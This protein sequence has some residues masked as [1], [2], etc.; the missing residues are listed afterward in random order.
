MSARRVALAIASSAV[1][2]AFP[3]TGTTAAREG[4]VAFEANWSIHLVK[5]DGSGLRVLAAEGER[6]PGE[7][8][9]YLYYPS[10]A[11]DGSRVTYVN[12]ARVTH[13]DVL[14]RRA[15]GGGP[16]LFGVDGYLL[17]SPL[18]FSPD[19]GSAAVSRLGERTGELAVFI[20]D[21]RGGKERQLT[22][23]PAPQR[24]TKDTRPDW[25]PDG[26]SIA[27]S[28]LQGTS[29][30]LM[31]VRVLGGPAHRLTRGAE[32]DWAPN[33]RRIAFVRRD[34]VYVCRRDGTAVRRIVKADGAASP[35][36]APDG[37]RVAYTADGSVWVV[38]SSGGVPVKIAN[39]VT[40][41][42]DWG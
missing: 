10:F 41:D 20:S 40:G 27:F 22:G 16:K 35:D 30:W 37:S 28:R 33:G 19:G 5:P 15:S 31:V 39:G 42:L 8:D 26:R 7:G 2:A 9:G 21:T 34:G 12:G 1:V 23:L 13:Q 6:S 14:V 36:F 4:L 24:L 38:S 17:G 11:P 18:S 3:G 32:A 29:A 25:S